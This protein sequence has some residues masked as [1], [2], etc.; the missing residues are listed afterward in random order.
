M[1]S[2]T[3][4]F[5]F[6]QE[7][8]YA[9]SQII[10]FLEDQMDISTLVLIN[11]TQ[12]FIRREF[13]FHFEDNLIASFSIAINVDLFYNQ[14]QHIYEQCSK[15]ADTFTNVRSMA[16]TMALEKTVGGTLQ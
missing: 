5:D 16:H 11:I 13:I 2:H 4:F 10:Q 3:H 9:I 12:D 8:D 15:Y 1:I 7:N 6:L 14:P